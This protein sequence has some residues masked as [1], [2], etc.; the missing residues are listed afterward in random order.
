VSSVVEE[1]TMMNLLV[2]PAEV[3]PKTRR[4]RFTMAET[5]RI[6]R[7]ADVVAPETGG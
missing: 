1:C 5:I 4:R 2:K 6:V 7:E 3:S